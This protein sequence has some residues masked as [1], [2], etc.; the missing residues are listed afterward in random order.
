[1][2]V[3]KILQDSYRNK[4][5]INDSPNF[6]LDREISNKHTKIYN[7]KSTGGML[8]TERGTHNFIHDIPTD[9][10]LLT[11][12]LNKTKRF[13]NSQKTV[14][15]AIEK[16]KPKNIRAISHSLGGNIINNLKLPENSKRITFNKGPDFF[17]K[18]KSENYRTNQDFISI[19]N[20]K[21]KNIGKGYHGIRNNKKVIDK[22]IKI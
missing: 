19:L 6:E 3:S 21:T 2:L 9:I 4:S 17:N 1:M 13:R 7:D 11:G 14:N 20:K 15:T 16:H 22:K 12:S 10:A 18:N 5:R 8:I